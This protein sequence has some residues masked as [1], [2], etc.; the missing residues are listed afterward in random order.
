LA[1]V[2][3]AH[4]AKQEA[5]LVLTLYFLALHPQVVVALAL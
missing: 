5:V 2:V 1:V 4:L 3:Q